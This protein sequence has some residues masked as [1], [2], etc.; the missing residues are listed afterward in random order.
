[1]TAIFL[2]SSIFLTSFLVAFSGAMMPGPLLTLT[3]AETPRRGI[4]TGPL[5]ISGHA[6]LELIMVFLLL[7][8]LGPYLQSPLSLTII[9]L[10]G[11]LVLLFMARGLLGALPVLDFEQPSPRGGANRNPLLAGIMASLANPYWTIWWVSIGLAT[12]TQATK[13]GFAGVAFFFAGHILADFLWYFLVSL[14]FTK[15]RKF[16]GEKGYRLIMRGCGLLLVI[17]G[18]W[19]GYTGFHA[20]LSLFN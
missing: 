8:G 3:I 10:G 16:I 6:I 13:L 12:I 9:G 19:F 5:L 18:L 14:G 1:M 11:A 17:F 2:L 4:W 20:G 15:G 7:F